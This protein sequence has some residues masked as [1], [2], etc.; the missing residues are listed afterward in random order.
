MFNLQRIKVFHLTMPS[1]PEPVPQAVEPQ[2]VEE[3]EEG[4]EYE[5][6]KVLAKKVDKK[7]KK[8]VYHIKWKGYPE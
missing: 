5:V 6:E 3:E 8:V 4:E 7:S 1:K 2:E